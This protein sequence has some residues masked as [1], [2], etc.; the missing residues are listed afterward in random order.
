MR[1]LTSGITSDIVNMLCS[2]TSTAI[3]PLGPVFVRS[4]TP[5]AQMCFGACLCLGTQKLLLAATAPNSPAPPATID[6]SS[7]R[8]PPLS[9]TRVIKPDLMPPAPAM[10]DLGDGVTTY[11]E[12]PPYRSLTR[13]AIQSTD[14]LNLINR[15]LRLHPDILWPHSGH[16]S[17]LSSALDNAAS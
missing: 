10:Q 16:T 8:A 6:T 15:Q 1:C 2:S 13:R 4:T 17:S 9:P 14:L 5:I 3:D 7:G 11:T 12:S